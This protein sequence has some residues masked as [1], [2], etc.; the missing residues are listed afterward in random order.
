[1]NNTSSETLNASQETRIQIYQQSRTALSHRDTQTLD[2]VVRKG[3][4]LVGQG[5]GRILKKEDVG[6]VR[7]DAEN[8]TIY[9]T[10]E[11]SCVWCK[12]IVKT[13]RFYCKFYSA[14]TKLVLIE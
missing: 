14:F 3:A 5:L 4:E 10:K 9:C 7:L 13:S 2:V 1:M 8:R 6:S 12:S 11:R